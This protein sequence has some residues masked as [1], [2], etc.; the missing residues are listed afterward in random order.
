MNLA[1]LTSFR[2][3]RRDQSGAAMVE[4]SILIGLIAALAIGIV[5]LLGTQVDGQYRS[6]TA[7]WQNAGANE[8]GDDEPDA[9]SNSNDP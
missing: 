2:V 4:Y 7:E 6:I 3:F 5:G 1:R 9:D 8:S